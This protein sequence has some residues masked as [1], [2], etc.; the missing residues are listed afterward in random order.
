MI[1][2]DRLRHALQ[3]DVG[4]KEW[5][6]A[7][8]IAIQLN[9]IR[10]DMREA[11]NRLSESRTG[12]ETTLPENQFPETWAVFVVLRQDLLK[13]NWN[14]DSLAREWVDFPPVEQVRRAANYLRA[15]VR[16]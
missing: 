13:A 12:L 2:L 6:I 9:S 11:L 3:I 15:A 1:D 10:R 16:R 14:L 4:S 5:P 7:R 8:D